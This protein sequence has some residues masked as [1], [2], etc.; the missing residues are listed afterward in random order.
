M[1][2]NWLA[3]L[4]CVVLCSITF[5]P[6]AIGANSGVMEMR[7]TTQQYI[8]EF[9]RGVN[10]GSGGSATGLV[11]NH[12]IEKSALSNLAR[13]LAV[14]SPEVRE[15][16]VKLLGKIGLELDS[17]PPGKF[18]IIRDHFVIKVLLTEGFSKDDSAAGVAE[19]LLREKCMPSDLAAFGDIYKKSL[20]QS[21]GDYLYLV[22]KAKAVQVRPLVDDLSKSKVWQQDEDRSRIIKIV[23]AALGNAAVE[24]GF[25]TAIIDAERDAPPAPKN[26][27]YEVGE[28]KDGKK[29]AALI[30]SLGLIGTRRSLL[31]TCAYLRSP[32]KSYVPDIK[33]RSVRYD[34]LDAI[35]YN[36]PDERILLHPVSTTEWAAA[37]QFCI[38]NL[39]AVF[40]GP[41]PDLPPDQP[42]PTRMQP[43]VV[44]AAR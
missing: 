6:S 15:N 8:D 30:G 35:R 20:R 19:V 28:A 27:F 31:L 42:Y 37:E 23:Q 39:G 1:M 4:T 16:I 10:I 29:V 22:A 2:K 13:E 38:D 40:D 12:R 17:P 5:I 41:T 26:R 21:K 33:E 14:G 44:G 18:P 36:F 24:D 43:R 7:K 11:M 3:S 9:R 32:L 34:A 25:I